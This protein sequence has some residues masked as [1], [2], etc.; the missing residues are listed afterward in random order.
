MTN[1]PTYGEDDATYQAAGQRAGI[2]ALIDTFFD[3]MSSNPAYRRIYDMHPPDNEASR[4]KLALFL[5]GW[6]GGP[7]FFVD[8]YGSISI[9]GVHAHLAITE[10]ERDMWL[11]CMCEAL[12]VQNYPP[13]LQT[14]LLEQLAFPAERIRE[15]CSRNLR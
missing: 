10:V 7:R 2:C 13:A 12:A 15:V 6:M 4:D 14:Y 3:I 1:N 5:C 11:S 9:P 8:K